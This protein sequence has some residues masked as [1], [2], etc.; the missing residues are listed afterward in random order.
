MTPEL[1]VCYYP[2]QWPEGLWAEDARRMTELSLSWVR[3]GEFAW[4]KI[5]PSE[6]VFDWSWLDRA[7]SVLGG[8][9]TPEALL[10][11]AVQRD[12]A[13]NIFRAGRI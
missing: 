3:I 9:C 4:S 13:E 1:G 11:D 8:H 7:I 2:E 12:Q 6:G 5:E 10:A